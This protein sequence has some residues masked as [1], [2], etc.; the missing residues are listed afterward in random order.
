LLAQVTAE[1]VS[2]KKRRAIQG[3]VARSEALTL[4]QRSEIAKKA[5]QARWKVE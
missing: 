1:Y 3:A 2:P 5:A 4:E